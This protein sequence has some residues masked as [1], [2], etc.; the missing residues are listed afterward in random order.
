MVTKYVLYI[1]GEKD[2]KFDTL[3][4]AHDA[5]DNSCGYHSAIYEEIDGVQGKLLHKACQ[6]CDC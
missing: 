3:E 5:D 6:F 1:D 2:E 4:E